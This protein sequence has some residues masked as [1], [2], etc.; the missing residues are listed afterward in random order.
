[1]PPSRGEEILVN[2]SNQAHL[3]QTKHLPRE[4]AKLLVQA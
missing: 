3:G 2:G 1:M 4:V